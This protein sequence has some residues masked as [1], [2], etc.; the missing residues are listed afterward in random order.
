MRHTSKLLFLLLLIAP[1]RAE[2]DIYM[3]EHDA[4]KIVLTN[5]PPAETASGYEVLVSEEKSQPP[6]SPIR[7]A[8]LPS[9]AGLPYAASVQQAARRSSR[10]YY[11][12]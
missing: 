11:T 3:L 9:A 4:D 12:P 7:P 6:A 2:A 1:W 8:T 10:P 5:L